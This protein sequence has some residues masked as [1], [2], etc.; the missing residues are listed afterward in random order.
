MF[1]DEITSINWLSN[2]AR[3]MER[4]EKDTSNDGS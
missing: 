4:A 3:N 1:N 2:N